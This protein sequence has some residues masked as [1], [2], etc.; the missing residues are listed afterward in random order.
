MNFFF[1]KKLMRDVNIGD[2][3]IYMKV[4]VSTHNESC[5]CIFKL[6]MYKDYIIIKQRLYSYIRI[7]FIRTRNIRI[8]N[9]CWSHDR[10]VIICNKI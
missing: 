7:L 1:N 3:N 5:V 9:I 10:D 2:V 4:N 6:I 8:Y